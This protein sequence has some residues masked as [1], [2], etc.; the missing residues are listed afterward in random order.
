MR[1]SI[2]RLLHMN[3]S[4]HCQVMPHQ[5]QSPDND[6]KSPVLNNL[7]SNPN[8]P[9]RLS[10]PPQTSSQ[11]LTYQPYTHLVSVKLRININIHLFICQGLQ[12]DRIPPH[13]LSPSPLRSSPQSQMRYVTWAAEV[14]VFPVCGRAQRLIGNE[15]GRPF[16]LPLK[17][18]VG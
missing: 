4:S 3:N 14:A 5:H 13:L 9:P 11:L 12:P 1:R 16:V 6:K 7:N 18:P 15:G 2:F 17:E 8:Y 10:V